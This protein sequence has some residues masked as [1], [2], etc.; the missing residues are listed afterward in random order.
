MIND[1]KGELESTLRHNDEIREEKH[2][3]MDPM[4]KEERVQMAHNAIIF[5]SDDE[6]DPGRREITTKPIMSS[7]ITSTSTAEHKSDHEE[8]PLKKNHQGPFT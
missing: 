6:S 5:S 2:V 7:N 1:A 4:R 8:T 3:R